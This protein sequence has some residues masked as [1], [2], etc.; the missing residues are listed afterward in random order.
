ME[1]ALAK[2]VDKIVI[3]TTKKKVDK[4]IIKFC[5]KYNFDYFVMKMM[6]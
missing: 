5:K 6:Y 4:E 1:R 2:K 3:A